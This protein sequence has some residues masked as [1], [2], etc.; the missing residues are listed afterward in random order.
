MKKIQ[1]KSQKK[2]KAFTILETLITLLAISIMIVGPVMFVT[3]SYHYSNFVK[4]KIIATGLSQEG[5]E[6]ATSLR[7]YKLK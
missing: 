4:A 6:L 2:I 3:K 7:N 5:L 1:K